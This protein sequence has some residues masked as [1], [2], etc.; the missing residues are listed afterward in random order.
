MSNLLQA[1]Q[2]AQDTAEAQGGPETPAKPLTPEEIAFEATLNERLKG[3]L[4]KLREILNAHKTRR[5]IMVYDTTLGDPLGLAEEVQAEAEEDPDAAEADPSAILGAPLREIVAKGGLEVASLKIRNSEGVGQSVY[6]VDI[7]DAESR[8]DRLTTQSLR[9]ALSE[10]M[11]A[12]PSP[13]KRTRSI[14]AWLISD[15][16]LPRLTERFEQRSRYPISPTE[17]RILRFWDPRIT[18][19]IGRLFPKHPPASW[20]PGT[21]WLYID[22]FGDLHTLLAPR[23]TDAPQENIGTL[24]ILPERKIIDQI[25]RVNFALQYLSAKGLQHDKSV[26]PAVFESVTVALQQGLPDERD[27]ARF[28]AHRVFYGKP[29]EMAPRMRKILEDVRT[30]G[31]YYRDICAGLEEEDWVEI[32][33][34]VPESLDPNGQISK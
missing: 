10:A 19:H 31:L 16:P 6:L 3:T 21:N 1:L 14:C 13:Y 11:Q 28:A 4:E 22:S 12:Q 29:L 5:L 26:L 15:E 18:Q 7:E 32:L 2:A 25:S 8:H 27:V 34:S 17:H 33:E 23:K 30:H 20:L 9:L 24:E